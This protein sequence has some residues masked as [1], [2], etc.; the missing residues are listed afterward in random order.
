MIQRKTS[1]RSIIYSAIE[2][3]KHSEI[4]EI[5]H[6]IEEK[7]EDVSIATIYRNLEVLCEADLIKT[8]TVNGRILYETVKERHY[9]FVC[10][11]CGKVHD[12]DGNNRSI[13]LTAPQFVTGCLVE[14]ADLTLYGVCKDCL[15]KDKKN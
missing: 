3:L 15:N 13:T 9:H 14:N 5:I 6:Y 7:H 2:E 1:Q 11:K 10:K 12:I 4:G 8:I